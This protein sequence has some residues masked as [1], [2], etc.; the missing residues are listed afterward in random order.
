MAAAHAAAAFAQVN[1]IKSAS[2]RSSGGVA[3]SIAGSTPA[4]PTSPT[5]SGTPGRDGTLMIQ[6]ISPD[7]LFSGSMVRQLMEQ[8][9]EWQRDGGK[10][11]FG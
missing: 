4:P 9:Q 11:V 7:A 5:G 10:V 6:G 1:A 3:P 2:F 8:V